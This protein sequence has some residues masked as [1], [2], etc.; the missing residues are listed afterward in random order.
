MSPRAVSKL[1]EKSCP[2]CQG[3][4][5]WSEEIEGS[6]LLCL[7]GGHR[8]VRQEPP[9]VHEEPPEGMTSRLYVESKINGL[10]RGAYLE[11]N[12]VDWLVCHGPK[13]GCT[14]ASAIRDYRRRYPYREYIQRH[15]YPGIWIKRI[16]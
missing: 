12:H 7:Q 9:P 15:G 2:V 3:D 10:D 8:F 6:E 11:V 4:V 13:D 5:L 14:L 16:Q 1:Y